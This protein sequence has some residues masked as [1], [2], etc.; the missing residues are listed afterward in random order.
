MPDKIIVA[1][2]CSI[3]YPS[4]VTPKDSR[5]PVLTQGVVIPDGIF[6]PAQ[7]KEHLTSGFAE[8]VSVRDQPDPDALPKAIEESPGQTKAPPINAGEEGAGGKGSDP[9]IL[10]DVPSG[11]SAAGGIPD[12]SDP[13]AGVRVSAETLAAEIAPQPVPG[14]EV[15]GA[16][17]P[18]S[19][20]IFNPAELAGK[21]LDELNIIIKERDAAVEP[22]ATVE[23]A[24]AFLSQNY[25]TE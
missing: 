23:E 25:I 21:P 2:G 14:P 1:R 7:I 6:T 19:H 3:R 9:V 15:D 24:I 5:R 13:G 18:V 22:F 8:S 16:G 20:W 10:D 11:M 17:S 12:A 4:G